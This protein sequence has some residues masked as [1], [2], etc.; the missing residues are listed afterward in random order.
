MVTVTP[1]HHF[2]REAHLDEVKVQMK[3]LGSPKLRG[4]FH[5]ET[6]IWFM[7]EGT[8]RLRAAKALGIAPTLVKIPWWRSRSALRQAIHAAKIYGHEFERVIEA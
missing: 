4:Y 2:Y 1:L 3:D 6:G 7:R 5:P 8:H